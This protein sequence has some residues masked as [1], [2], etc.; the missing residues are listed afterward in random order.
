MS[1]TFQFGYG[2]KLSMYNMGAVGSGVIQIAIAIEE[3]AILTGATIK[4]IIATK[5]QLIVN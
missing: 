5:T 1:D 4:E 2:G 3:V